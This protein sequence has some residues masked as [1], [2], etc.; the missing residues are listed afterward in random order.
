MAFRNDS[1]AND[2]ETVTK[3][4]TAFVDYIGILCGGAGNLVVT[5][6]AGND[7]TITGVLAG[8]YIP[9]RIIKVKSTSTTTT[10]MTGFKA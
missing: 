3:S 8:Q 10:N 9:L 2:A 5:T 6:G 1:I 7:V 4:D